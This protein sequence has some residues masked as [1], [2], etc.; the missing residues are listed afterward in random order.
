MLRIT[1]SLFVTFA[2]SAFIFSLGAAEIP[3]P[4]LI[5]VKHHGD[6]CGSCKKMGSIFTDLRNKFDGQ[7][8]LF[9]TLDLTNIS[10]RNQSELLAAALG[11]QSVYKN[12]PGTGF[13][14]LVD[15]K[16][17]RVVKKLTAD[18]D[19]KTMSKAIAAGLSSQTR[20]FDPDIAK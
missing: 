3:S 4:K 17:H 16:T 14:L 5:A 11:L 18:Q 1:A 6:W 2:L 12:N 13:I 8:V 15:P 20:A 19:I 10:T 7:P 9:V